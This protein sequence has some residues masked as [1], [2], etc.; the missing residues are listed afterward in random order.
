[1][2]RPLEAVVR[3]LKDK[4]VRFKGDIVHEEAGSFAHLEDPDGTP[5]YLWQMASIAASEP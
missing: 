4:G 1:M 3:E 2:N 5:I